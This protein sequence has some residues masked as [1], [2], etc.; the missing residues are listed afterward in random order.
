M[1]E[2]AAGCMA[3]L[4]VTGLFGSP[5]AASSAGAATARQQPDARAMPQ[6]LWA[7]VPGGRR[8]VQVDAAGLTRSGRR[9]WVLEPT[10]DDANR[11]KLVLIGGLDGDPASTAI[12]M[13]VLRWWFTDRAAAALRAE[14]QIAALPCARPDSCGEAPVSA[15]E[16]TLSFPPPGGFFDGKLD[17]T[18]HYVWRW[19]TMQAPT[20]VIDVRAGTAVSWSANA[21]ATG[22][23]SGPLQAQGGSAAPS[24]APGSLIGALADSGTGAAW[25]MPVPA[26]RLDAASDVAIG[27]IAGVLPRSARASSPLR[28]TLL[29]RAGRA[30]LDVARLLAPKYPAQPI[31]SYIPALSWSGALRLA[32]L[33]GEA[34][35]REKP[36]AEMTP[37]VSGAKPAIAE[38]YLLTSLAGHLALSD[39]GEL[40]GNAEAAAVARKGA[41]FMLPQARDQR[42]AIRNQEAAAGDQGE[43]V[44]FPRAWT[45]DMFMAVSVLARAAA[46]TKGDDPYAAT[47]GRLLTTYAEQLQRPDGIFIHAKEGPHAWGRG[48]GFAAFGLMEALTYLPASSPDRS[49]VLQSYQSLMKGLIGHQAPD[50]MWRQVVDEPGSYREFTV[51]AMVVTAMARGVRLGWLDDSYRPMVSRAWQGLLARIAEDGSLMDVCTGTGSGPTKQYYLDRAGVTGADDRGGAMGLTAALEIEELNR[52][53]R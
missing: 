52:V 9:M 6:A 16:G 3:A 1:M 4:L 44:R 21:A 37:F 11:P 36:V 2:R 18:P 10:G 17:P 20:I 35:F 24:S 39:W 13:R 49:R 42:A 22:V 14:W 46:R 31:M 34:R 28:T 19:T 45:D 26:F 50:G 33:T 7:L 32:K 23:L 47:A 43:I 8:N 51:T 41:D 12:V 5:A 40:E 25:S 15:P 38:P 27:A 53:R 48:N 29:A 30:P